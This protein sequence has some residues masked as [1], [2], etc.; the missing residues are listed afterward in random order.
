[1][2]AEDVHGRHVV[3]RQAC[4]GAYADRMIEDLIQEIFV[5]VFNEV[6]QADP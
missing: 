2:V 5:V 6:L 1:M 3:G 4:L